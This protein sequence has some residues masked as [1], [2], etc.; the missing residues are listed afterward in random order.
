MTRAHPSS[1]AA[2]RG[3]TLIELLVAMAIGLVVTLA[4]TSTLTV[5][6]SHKRSTTSTNDMN[7]SGNY[8]AYVLDRALRS[9][10]SGFA[11]TGAKEKIFGCRLQAARESAAILPRSTAF[12]APFASV[13]GGA[14]AA[15]AGDLRV[16]PVLI[17]KSQSAGGSDVLVVMSGNAASGDVPRQIRELN[18]S[19][20]LRLNNTVGLRQN[21]IFLVSN[22]DA[23]ISTDCLIEQASAPTPFVDS[24]GNDLLPLGGTYYTAGSGTTLAALIGGGLPRLTPLG[25]ADAGN[26]QFQM[27]GVDANRTL[28]AYDLLQSNG[29]DAPQAVSDG[30]LRMHAMYGFKD[31]DG[32]FRSNWVAPDAVGFDIKSMMLDA[33][34][35][36]QL[37]AVRVAMVVRSAHYEKAE[38]A[39]TVPEIFTGTAGA[40]AAVPLTGDDRHFRHRIVEF[41]VP[42]RNML[43]RPTAAAAP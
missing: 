33:D 4:V 26:V 17:G 16:A 28:F 11:Q 30:V 14:G 18:G 25:N 37:V 31:A 6:E 27:F 24:A 35:L 20:N 32:I 36:D 38:V 39:T 8:G 2:P 23:A 5:G 10:G 9:A 21:D 12:P 42:L 13:L 41:T 43:L 3:F 19:N 22:S 40:V 29:T 34:K 7:Q 1:T 15:N